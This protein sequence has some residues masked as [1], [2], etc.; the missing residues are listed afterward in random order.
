MPQAKRKFTIA[1]K[2]DAEF[3]WEAGKFNRSYHR[4]GVIR[5]G[6]ICPHCEAGAQGRSFTDFGDAPAWATTVGHSNPWEIN[7]PLNEAP[8]AASLPASLYKFDPFHV[9]KFGVFRDAVASCVVQLA[10]MKYFDFIDGESVSIDSRFERAYSLYKLWTLGAGKSA[11]LKKFTK[12][13]FNFERYSQ[14]PWVNCK[15]SEVTLLLMWLHFLLG[16]ILAKPPKE[17]ADLLPL[18]AMA[19]MIEGALNFVGIMHSHGLHLPAACA[20]LQVRAGMTFIR[21]YAWNAKLC[22][23]LKAAG[24]RL[25][26]KLHY[27]HHI[28]FEAQRQL[29]QG[30]AFVL[31]SSL[32]L[33]ENNEDFIGRLSR[34]S[35]RVAAKTA[36]LR[37][38]QRYLVKCRCLLERLLPSK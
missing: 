4:T 12:S 24:F 23:G 29:D 1:C 34:I 27:M 25:R 37:T 36:G 9:T 7:P 11:T 8:F 13:N 5:D 3:H 16:N 19:Q 20:R 6:L 26:P 17:P 32:W 28:L 35:R 22:M 2:G 18:R 21:G 10:C 33:C 15:G 38:T 31:S 30:D 14:F